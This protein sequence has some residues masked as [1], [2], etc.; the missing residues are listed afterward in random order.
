[1]NYSIDHFTFIPDC[2]AFKISG[3]LY[4]KLVHNLG[5]H[6]FKFSAEMDN[7]VSKSFSGGLSK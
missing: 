4:G 3:Y 6:G 7:R 1:M 5:Y 2:N